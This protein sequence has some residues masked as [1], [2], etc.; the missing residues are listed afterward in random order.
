MAHQKL[1]DGHFIPIGEQHQQDGDVAKHSQEYDHPNGRAQPLRAHHIFA[2]I[3]CI[4]SRIA[5]DVDFPTN[6]GQSQWTREFIAR[7]K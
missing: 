6:D 7:A 5:F 3:Q 4:R 2:R 1:W